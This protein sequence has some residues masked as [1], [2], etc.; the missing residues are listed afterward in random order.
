MYRRVLGQQS[1][2]NAGRP[3]ATTTIA[4]RLQHRGSDIKLPVNSRRRQA[5]SEADLVRNQY[6]RILAK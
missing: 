4:V 6:H 5:P 3:P 2:L 1:V